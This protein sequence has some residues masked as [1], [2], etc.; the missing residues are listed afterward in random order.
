MLPFCSI[1]HRRSLIFFFYC[2]YFS[3]SSHISHIF[4][5]HLCHFHVPLASLAISI[6]ILVFHHTKMFKLNLIQSQ[7]KIGWVSPTEHLFFPCI[8]QISTSI[9]SFCSYVFFSLFFLFR[10]NANFLLFVF[11]IKI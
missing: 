2:L 3:I 4:S 8:I 10:K 6:L 11:E 1:C 7:K 9:P 5:S